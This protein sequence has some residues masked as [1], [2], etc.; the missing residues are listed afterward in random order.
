VELERHCPADKSR[1]MV[2]F[3]SNEARGITFY[4]FVVPP[5]QVGYS[6]LHLLT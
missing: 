3:Y 1:K 5:L 4:D 6:L 2:L